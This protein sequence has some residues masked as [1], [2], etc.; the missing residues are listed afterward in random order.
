MKKNILCTGTC[1]FLMGNFVRRAIYEK[2]PYSFISIDRASNNSINSLYWNKNHTFHIADITDQH[3]LDVHF[4]FEHPDIV[5]H[6]AAETS[7][8]KSF[9]DP[10]LFIKNNISGTQSVINA[11][12]KHNVSKI[13]FLSTNQVYGQLTSDSESSWTEDSVLNPRNTYAVTKATAEMLIKNSGLNYNIIRFSNVYGPRQSVDKLIP[14]TIK[15]IVQNKLI[16]VYGKGDQIRDWT[17]F[18]D[19]YSSIIN[20]LD[21]GKNNEIYNVG[22]GQE[23]SNIEVIQKIC[24]VVGSGYNLITSVD[25][26]RRC[27]DFRYSMNCDKIKNIGWKPTV[28]FKDGIIETVDWY[29]NNNWFL[30]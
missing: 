10:E 1:G 24:N 15:S 23:F 18:I 4:Q 5:I 29:K 7:V 19:A 30:K 20:V 8:D 17:H 27:H 13:I 6:G 26:P 16:N 28:K 9:S 21:N 11:C 25:D 12:L 22:S 3:I 2:Q 14:N